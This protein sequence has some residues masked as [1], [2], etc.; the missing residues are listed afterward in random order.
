[1]KRNEQL[2]EFSKMTKDDLQKTLG[3]KQEQLRGFRFDLVGGK[4]KD[5]S[6]IRETRKAIAR[7]NTILKSR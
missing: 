4:V 5:V 6:L 3:E 1:M 2:R 7:V